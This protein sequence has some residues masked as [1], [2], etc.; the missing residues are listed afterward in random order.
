MRR[1]INRFSI[2]RFCERHHQRGSYR[3]V[4]DRLGLDCRWSGAKHV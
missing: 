1:E 3:R 4:F 2:K